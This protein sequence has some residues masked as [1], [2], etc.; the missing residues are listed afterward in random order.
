MSMRG[1][2]RGFG[3]SIRIDA[4]WAGMSIRGGMERVGKSIRGGL[5][6]TRNV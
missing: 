2:R 5:M 3:L 1:G 6:R 4:G